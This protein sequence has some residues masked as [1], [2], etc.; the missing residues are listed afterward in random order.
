MRTIRTGM[1]LTLVALAALASGATAQGDAPGADRDWRFIEKLRA[2]GMEDLALRQLENFATQ[3]PNDPRAPQAL[4]EAARGEAE[5]GRPLRARELCEDLLERF[6][7]AP[8][9]PAAALLRADQ[10]SD[11]ARW[12]EASESY[13]ALL[14]AYPGSGEASAARLGLGEVLMAQSRDEEAR[15]LFSGLLSADTPSPV[16]ARAR[17]DLGVLDL[18]AGADSLA[19]ERFE[20]IHLQHP[21]DPI[22]AFGLVRAAELLEAREANQAAASRYEIVIENYEN[23]VLRARAR[24]GLARL[25][26]EED[27]GRAADLY[28]A[29]LEEGASHEDLRAA[30]LGLGRAALADGDTSLAGSISTAFLERFGDAPEADRARL[31]RA[32]ALLEDEP[33]LGVEALE[34][35]GRS[36]DA[37]VAWQSMQILAARDLADGNT[38]AASLRWRQAEANATDPERKAVA[39]LQQTRIAMD[40][41]RFALASDLA[42][43]ITSTTSVDTLAA[44][45]LQLA[46]RA[47]ASSGDLDAAIVNASRCSREYPLA[48]ASSIAR[49]DL[50]VWTRMSVTD[51]G[52][53]ARELSRI[54]LDPDLDPRARALEVGRVQRDLMGEYAPAALSFGAA[55][56]AGG[57]PAAISGA[58]LELARTY[59]L[60]ALDAG[61]RGDV[62][63]ARDFLRSARTALVAVASRPGAEVEAMRGRIELYGLDL[64][65]SARP[66]APWLFDP[67]TMPL[68]GAVGRAEDVDPANAELDDTRRRIAATLEEATGDARAWLAWRSAELSRGE[69]ADRLTLVEDGL[70]AARSSDLKTTLTYTRGHL[71]LM[72]EDAADAA[73]DFARV[74]EQEELVE[75]S[76]AARY[77][78]AE[79]QRALRRYDQAGE[80]YAEFAAA[81]PDTRRGQRAMLL[82][83]DC[84]LFAGRPDDAVTTYRTLL[85][86]YPESIY[87]DDA[88]YRLGTALERAGKVEAARKPLWSLVESRDDSGY[89]GRALARLG[90]IEQAAGQDSLAVVVL[91]QLVEADP[92]RAADEDAWVTLARL[93]LGLDHPD[94]ALRWARSQPEGV[95]DP[96]MATAMEVQALAALGRT[97]E[98]G[99]RLEDLSLANPDR[100]DLIAEARVHVAEALADA[101]SE[102]SAKSEF[103]RARSEASRRETI[104]RAAYGEGMIAVRGQRWTEAKAA[105]E[106]ARETSPGSDWA[107]ESMFKLGQIYQREGNA[108]AARSAFLGIADN[109]PDHPRAPSSL[110][111]LAQVWRSEGRYDEAVKAYHRILDDYP[112]VEGAPQILASIAY[113]HHEMG[114][115]EVAISAYRQVMPL[116]DEE[117]QA[118]AQFW[119]ADSLDQLGRHEEAAAEFLKIPFLFPEMGQLGVTAQLKAGEAWEHLGDLEAARQIYERV[120]AVHGA[121][122]QWG[123]EATRRLERLERAAGE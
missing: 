45:G 26:E 25:I 52:L 14:S 49:A 18:K 92:D 102:G 74:V 37:D 72:G 50:A 60:A 97:S 79:A 103:E 96:A 33:D 106:M 101:G 55:R 94:V 98:A 76:V 62:R 31:I 17:F 81:W 3:Y 61:L 8:E 111:A 70:A 104:A 73:R 90:R 89:R 64:A 4:L 32:R 82:A 113:C 93:E 43:L 87:R 105:F 42:L 112:E 66:D 120:L 34:D 77:G 117:E 85:D 75:L 88:L 30:Y 27:P 2:D 13:R 121:Q 116:L 114:K 110:R 115:H 44:R 15:R 5:L 47:D 20:S 10:L 69:L 84:S 67:R 21:E 48:P 36:P 28:R 54:A 122:S 53:A 95:G 108:A 16:A 71:R 11:E 6:P 41:G 19:I 58:E 109:F 38:D 63:A 99:E 22:G 29:V 51:D 23:P 65:A 39:L 46:A 68:L 78:L 56:D 57:E 107:A 24:L 83:G 40:Q 35:L 9:A 1:I 7:S 119:I 118:Y 59:Q 91:S 80:L 100:P 123:L 12:V 86:R